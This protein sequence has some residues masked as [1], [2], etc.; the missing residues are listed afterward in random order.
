M[1]QTCVCCGSLESDLV[2]HV[3]LQCP[4]LAMERAGLDAVCGGISY[5]DCLV[6]KPGDGHFQ[7]A[8][9][10]ASAVEVKVIQFWRRL[11]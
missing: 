6:A 3:C 4:V 11:H 7:S 8:V 1:I 5:P 10:L 9:E 2:Q